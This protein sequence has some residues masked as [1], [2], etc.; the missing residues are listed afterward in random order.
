MAVASVNFL[1]GLGSSSLFVDEG[2]SWAAASAPSLGG[3]LDRVAQGE[4][5]PP[6]HYLGLH[7]VLGRVADSEFAMRL[8]SAL[9]GIAVVGSI[10]WVGRAVAGRRA[11]AFAAGLG[12]VS[13]LLL[14]YSQQARSYIFAMLAATLAVGALL[15]AERKRGRERRVWLAG[16]AVAAIVGFWS[17]YT[18]ALVVAPLLASSLRRGCLRRREAIALGASI[19]AGWLLVAPIMLEQLGQGRSQGLAHLA[20][21]SAGNLVE[22]LGA[23]FDTRYGFFDITVP[24]AVGALTVG[25]S[26][27]LA[28]A[29]PREETLLIRSLILP[30]TVVPMVAVVLVT[31]VGTDVLL[32]RY[33]A[34]AVPFMLILIG[35]AVDVLGG[36]RAAVLITA[37]ALSALSGSVLGHTVGGH[38]A[39]WRDATTK[40]ADGARPGDG[41]I[42]NHPAIR[43]T[44]AYYAARERIT[45][46]PV[47]APSEPG[48]QKLLRRRQR[49][50]MAVVLPPAEAELRA[51]LERAFGYR[52]QESWRSDDAERL[53]LVLLL[54]R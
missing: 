54:P 26:I 31:I 36:W 21:L 32:T 7:E 44:Y 27:A 6:L 17:H 42:L 15:E 41:V 9:A 25:V 11:A 24:A 46:L 47:A 10:F 33:V 12:A 8:P 13:P 18:V 19:G 14:E 51:G 50:W 43:S 38:Y 39:A 49:L 3:V 52:V 34:V 53:A 30:L 37:A 48:V 20:F 35:A 22:L 1:V 16:V 2:L 23:P 28:L 40:I 45:H 5:S 29:R 4:V